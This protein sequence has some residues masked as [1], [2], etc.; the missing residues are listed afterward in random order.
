MIKKTIKILIIII[1]L[2][3]V[4]KMIIIY[5]EYQIKKEADEIIIEINEHNNNTES[6]YRFYSEIEYHEYFSGKGYS[7]E[8]IDYAFNKADLDYCQRLVDL[9]YEPN[10]LATL[11]TAEDSGFT[12]GDIECAYKQIMI[13]KMNR[14]EYVPSED[15]YETVIQGDVNNG[16]N[17]S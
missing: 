3:S 4:I 10:L 7:E 15:W 9:Y 17:K 5:D 1:V 12:E 8:A 14:G 11:E 6:W 16:D 13:D 2:T